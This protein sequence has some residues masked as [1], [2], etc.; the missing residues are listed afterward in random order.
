[1]TETVAGTRTAREL[2][3][4]SRG[5]V[6]PALRAAVA[7][8]PESMR[9]LVSYHFGWADETGAPASGGGGKAV[10]PALVLAAA[11]AVG[12]WG[13]ALPGAVAV[14]LVHN[15]SLL[16]DDVMDGDETRRHRPTVWKLFGAGPAILAGDSLLVAASDVLAASGHPAA[17]E[18]LRVLGA[19]VQDLIEGQG[20][21]LAFE[22]RADVGLDECRLMAEGKTG[23]LLGCAC[24]LGGL[25]GGGSSE[26]V[27]HLRRFGEAAGLAFQMVDDLLG[28]WGDPAATGK[29]VFSDLRNR[30]KSL[31]VVAALTSGTAA[32][33]ELASLYAAPGELAGSDLVRAARLVDQAGGREWT[34][35]EAA[36]LLERARAHLRAAVPDPRGAADLEALAA[37]LA[38]RDR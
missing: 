32:G 13:P 14:E 6:D 23:A 15:F 20:A 34:R 31:P 38:D 8:L 33:R 18:A 4:W 30:K 36:A 12:E 16:H 35:T 25:L 22:Q 1:M 10:R 9:P 7:R 3:A 26:Q 5:C 27:A 29:P 2:L 19:A 11:R 28:I 17:R 24:A 37:L 21:D